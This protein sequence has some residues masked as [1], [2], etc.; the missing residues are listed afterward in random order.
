M[1]RE[2]GT[3]REFDFKPLP[4]WELGESLDI[5]DL[6]RGAK[7]AGSGFVLFKGQGAQLQRALMNFMI[8]LHVGEHGYKEVW[9]PLL[10]NRTSMTSTG[11]WINW[12]PI[13]MST[14]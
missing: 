6:P 10:S 3:K 1:V 11:G 5:L 8:D 7:M 13:Q 4:H 9:S 12:N 14:P 2:W